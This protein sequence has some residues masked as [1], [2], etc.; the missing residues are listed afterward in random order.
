[1]YKEINSLSKEAVRARMLQN[2]VKLWG[3]KST[4]A[5]DPFASLLID[6]FSTEI[7]KASGE[8]QAVN[9][10]ILEKL[11]RL[12]TP[13]IYTVPQPAHAIAFAGADESRELLANHSEFFVTRQFPST[14]KAV[15]DVQVDIHFTPVDDVALVNMQTAMMFSATHGY[16]I[17]AQQNRIPLL[18]LPAEVMAPHK[19]VLG[20]D[21][22]GYTDELF[23][24]KISLYCANPAFEHLDFVYK[25]LPFV[26]VKQQGHMLRV[27][28]GISFEGRQA[29]EGY[30]EIMRE[31]AMRTRIEGHIKNA[32]RHQFVELYGLQAAPERSELPE[33]LA[34]VMAHK[35][36]ARALEDKKL[37][38]LE[39]SFPP[40]YT[41][42][43][44]DQFS[45]TLN[46]FPVYNRKWKSNEYA[47]D[48]MGDNVPLSTDNGEHFLYVED[49]MD[50]FG[51]KYREVPFSKTND[52]QKGLYTVR[53]GG[54]ERFNERNAIEMIAN[55]LELTRDEVSAFGVLE[56]DKV[57]EALKSMT[58][59]MR[60]LEQ[61]VV[62][63][64]RATR[65]E[66]NY[67]IV[68]PIGHI[69]HLRA[70]YWITNCDLANGIR[71]GTS[72]T[73]PK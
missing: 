45:F 41:A 73:Q 10:R 54:M 3:L 2:A 19:I 20:I 48:I 46:A 44:L 72:L 31:Y 68:D 28:A 13:S 66:T 70:A 29:E 23:P 30:E 18:R 22:S 39:L 51:N 42:D 69:E 53:T 58:A 64:E 9:S 56:R 52:L 63:A 11:A 27:S 17:D 62:N 35:E 65:Q 7:S 6:A 57:V 55:V 59:Q 33:N 1:M 8:I 40:Q 71:R 25:L 5:V 24:E 12:L 37:I 36:V 15:S 32:Y 4:T 14:A 43:I 50:S 49:V 47:L 21:C 34:F 38:W 16:Y 26:Q 60:L 61:K 67:V